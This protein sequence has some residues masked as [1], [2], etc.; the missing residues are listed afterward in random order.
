VSDEG[1]GGEVELRAL[2]TTYARFGLT[3]RHRPDAR[4]AVLRWQ[5]GRLVEETIRVQAANGSEAEIEVEL[6]H[7]LACAPSCRR[8][9]EVLAPMF[10]DK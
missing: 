3:F 8:L 5:A 7:L 10:D 6:F 2:T 1:S 9:I 4:L